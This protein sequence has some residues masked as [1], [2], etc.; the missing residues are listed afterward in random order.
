MA[1]WHVPAPLRRTLIALMREHLTA[2]PHLRHLE[3]D[4]LGERHPHAFHLPPQHAHGRAMVL[5]PG[6]RV[7]TGQMRALAETLLPAEDMGKPPGG[8]LD[9]QVLVQ[10]AAVATDQERFA[11][12]NPGH[13]G[14]LPGDLAQE[15]LGGAVGRG[16]LDD[17]DGEALP[18][19]GLQEAGV[20]L[21]FVPPIG[22][23]RPSGMILRHRHPVVGDPSGADRRALEAVRPMRKGADTAGRVLAGEADQVNGGVDGRGLQRVRKG[24]AVSPVTLNPAGPCGDRPALPARDTG[25]LVPPREEARHEAGAEMAGAPDDADAHV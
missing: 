9:V 16:R 18:V 4:P 10:G 22:G 5:R 24:G 17:G 21:G 1:R 20:G 14:H 15:A 11:L 8:L 12:A 3:G 19:M 25:D 6:E 7:P 13:P 23:D 2:D